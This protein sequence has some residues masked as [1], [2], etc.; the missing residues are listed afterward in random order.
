M[1]LSPSLHYPI[2]RFNE[3]S[4]KPRTDDS[5][6]VARSQVG[7][8]Q[9]F[10][11]LVERYQQRIH[12]VCFR[13]LGDSDAEDATQEVF[14]SAF[15]NIQRY[16]GGSFV[17]WL[18]RIASNKCLDYLRVQKR[19]PYISLDADTG[20]ADAPPLEV[21]DPGE[22]PED[23]M[24]RAELAHRLE[25]K[26]QELPADQRLAIILSDIQGYNHEEIMAATGWPPAMVKSRLSRGRARMRSALGSKDTGE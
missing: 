19:R 23:G 22:G 26:L 7:D 14:L 1:A 3:W 11:L 6:L 5:D 4:G 9:A 8:V 17:A 18:L 12:A 20:Y 24:L 2:S 15:R 10:N 16:R 25:I 13:L 21:S